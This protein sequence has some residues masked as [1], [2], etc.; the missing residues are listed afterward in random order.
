MILVLV[1]TSNE[2]SQQRGTRHMLELVVF[3]NAET[4]FCF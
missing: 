4:H 2:V 1:R 3:E